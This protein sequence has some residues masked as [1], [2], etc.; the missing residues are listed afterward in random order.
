MSRVR[1]CLILLIAFG[2]LTTVHPQTKKKK[3]LA[4]GEVK[5]WQHDSVSH[6]LATIEKL[7]YDSGLWDTYIRT[8]CQLVTKKKVPAGN[9]KNL[10]DFDAVAFYTTGELDMDDSQ[11]ADLLSFVHDDGKGFIGIHSAPDT[12]YK[13]P[14]YGEMLGGYFDEHPWMTFDA[15]VIVEDP[16]F[17]AMK[18]F[19]PSFT[20]HD[21]IYQLKDW[22]R[23]KCRVLMRLDPNKLD[24]HNPRVHRTDKDFAVAYAKMYGKGRVFYSTL[25]H[26]TENWDRKDVQTMYV[27]AI[28]WAMGMEPGDATPRPLPS[29]AAGQ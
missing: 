11:K 5:G 3:L 26:V 12:F 1:L 7:G 4:I 9:A 28:K 29:T 15:P 21:E 22:S 10:N 25:G 27:E 24:L 18:A 16:G 17:P 14:E 20:I 2:A 8:D 19:P 6:A 13:W 23:D